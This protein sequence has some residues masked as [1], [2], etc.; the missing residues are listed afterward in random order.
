MAKKSSSIEGIDVRK[1][2]PDKQKSYEKL[3]YLTKW[4]FNPERY[5]IEPLIEN[6]SEFNSGLRY[7]LYGNILTIPKIV[8]YVNKHLNHIDTF[9]STSPDDL[10]KTFSD[11][12]RIYG[13]KNS[14][15]LHFAK[16]QTFKRDSF[17]DIIQKYCEETNSTLNKQD[18]INLYRLF[19]IG[20]I[21]NDEIEG[22][23]DIIEGK[24]KATKG[25]SFLK[26][27]EEIKLNQTKSAEIINFTNNLLNFKSK[28]NPCIQCPLFYRQ[29][30]VIDT[31]ISSFTDIPVDIAIVAN[32]TASEQDIQT[33]SPLSGEDGIYFR[34]L[35]YP[36]V[37]KYNLKYIITNASLCFP[38]NK[39][40]S[41]P[42]VTKKIMANCRGMIDEIHSSFKPK[43]IVLF[44]T[45]ILR[46]YGIKD[47]ITDIN[48]EIVDKKY[49]CMTSPL[50]ALRSKTHMDRFLKAMF[51]LEHNISKSVQ[52]KN[53]E[54]VESKNNFNPD[55]N[56]VQNLSVTSSRIEKGD[57][58]FNIET[59]N[60]QLVYVFIDSNNKKKYI[61]EQIQYPIFIKNGKYQECDYIEDDMN[62]KVILSHKQKQ[63]LSYRLNQNI[64]HIIEC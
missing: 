6:S 28:R 59:F 9:Y 38:T 10:L 64:K 15:S 46:N 47:K 25:S 40:E 5:N 2:K 12:I 31:N 45:S 18:I 61:I 32:E 54:A 4:L 22:I 51:L 16:F 7:R 48:G 50:E 43:L 17:S 36:L 26:P 41:E 19:E 21:K 3:K 63:N 20:I 44:G 35:F 55:Q 30:S 34:S 27:A 49:F 56:N 60:D 8:W 52:N 23:E 57:T 13:L 39:K 53:L 62:Y 58:L 29:T 24:E 1:I 42:T 33:Q 37:Q 14:S 11:I